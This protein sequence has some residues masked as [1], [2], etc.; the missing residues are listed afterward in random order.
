MPPSAL[1]AAPFIADA[2]GEQRNVTKAA[3]SSGFAQRSNNEVRPSPSAN[4]VLLISSGVVIWVSA[5][6]S[7][8][9]STP[10]VQ[11]GAARTVLTV[12]LVP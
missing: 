1:S 2:L 3:I 7:M 4:Y 12:T 9:V 5:I 8:K 6:C 10:L 11:V